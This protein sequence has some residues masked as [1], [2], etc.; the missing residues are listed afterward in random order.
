MKKKW[1]KRLL[2]LGTAILM[3]VGSLTAFASDYN[4]GNTPIIKAADTAYYQGLI[5]D[6]APETATIQITKKVSDVN[7]TDFGNGAKPIQGVKF[8]IK[9]VGVLAQVQDG[10][11][12]TMVYGIEK[13]LAQKLSITGKY[14][15][16]S[17]QY[18]ENYTG[19]NEA[20]RAKTSHELDEY[21]GLVTKETNKEGIITYTDQDYGLYLIVETDV[22]KATVDGE[23]I[24]ITRTQYPYVVSAPIYTPGTDGTEG[25][26]SATVDAKAK[27][28]TGTAGSEKK[29][30]DGATAIGENGSLVDND[31]TH[32]GDT[33]VFRLINDIIDLSKSE[34]DS[35]VK[36]DTYIVEDNMSRGL[37]FTGNWKITDSLSKS[38]AEGTDYQ[39]I[40]LYDD[41]SDYYDGG[42]TMRF[43]FT[44]TGLEKLTE[45]AKS[46]NAEKKLYVEYTAMVN[47]DAV[48]GNA[49]NPN[50]SRL[51]FSANGGNTITTS[52]D[53]VK[54]YIF[55]I[56]GSKVFNGNPAPASAQSVKFAL[57]SDKECKNAL[58][59][60]ETSEDGV[61]YYGGTSNEI[62]LN[63]DS[64]FSLKGVPADGKTT[65]YLK[66]TATADGY[67]LLKEPLEIKLTADEAEWGTLK[68]GT[69]D[70]KNAVDKT[71]SGV[72]SFTVNN[73]SGFQLPSTGGMGVW[74]FAIAAVLVIAAGIVFLYRTKE[75]K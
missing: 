38:Y 25:S 45:A 32:I 28:D 64:K 41:L 48:I 36:I 2:A 72:V 6:G 5:G 59:V 56:E 50:H 55:Q 39:I 47:E 27:N 13:E 53:E 65:L 19:I 26:W 9:K 3:S 20:L 52:W 63:K 62:T 8:G 1:F 17:Y 18:V 15:D 23:P 49:G 74:L 42:T 61:Y 21:V 30:I 58:S 75:Q 35:E 40:S 66:E 10:H 51:I 29:I 12:T 22:S 4:S 70:G 43:E 37:T 44:D 14:S 7:G 11:A 33:V 31:D 60:T 57:Y 24:T 16:A 67:N 69:V 73:T 54:E 68:I 34:A 71:Q 46:D